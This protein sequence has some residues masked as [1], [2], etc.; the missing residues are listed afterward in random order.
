MVSVMLPASTSMIKKSAFLILF[1]VVFSANVFSVDLWRYPQTADRNSIFIGC[2]FAFF[3]FNISEPR[4]SS[5]DLRL[6]D[7]HIDYVLPVGFPLSLGVSLNPFENGV[8]GIGIRPAYHINL[9]N[10]YLNLYIM[11]A[12]DWLIGSNRTQIRI[13]PR[14]GLRFRFGSLP[15]MPKIETSILTTR[16]GFSVKVF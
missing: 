2:H 4:N 15:L 3:F 10:T 16:I 13:E 11:C 14:V 7:F 6:P 1:T 12:V 9:N 8:F 5:F